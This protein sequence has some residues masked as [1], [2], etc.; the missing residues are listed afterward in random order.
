MSL[1]PREFDLLDYFIRHPDQVLSR[2]ALH[3]AVW[4]VPYDGRS[5]VVDV[6]VQYLRRKTEGDGGRRLIHTVRGEGYRFVSVA[7]G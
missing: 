2:A 6:Y 5:N 1:S 7:A 4:Q 3:Q